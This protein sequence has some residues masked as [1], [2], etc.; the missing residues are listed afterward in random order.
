MLRRVYSVFARWTKEQKNWSPKLPGFSTAK[1][2]K[3]ETCRV[4][5]WRDFILPGRVL[6]H[7]HLEHLGASDYLAYLIVIWRISGGVARWRDATSASTTQTADSK[8]CDRPLPLMSRR[9][10]VET[11]HLFN[12][13]FRNEGID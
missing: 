13:P 12:L 2:S 1:Q 4:D 11:D 6:W 9:V 5:R 3:T 8:Y 7:E 10:V